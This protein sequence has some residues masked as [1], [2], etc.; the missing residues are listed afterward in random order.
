MLKTEGGL[1]RSFFEKGSVAGNR[2][3][4]PLNLFAPILVQIPACCWPWPGSSLV[5][6]QQRRLRP[7]DCLQVEKLATTAT[8][9]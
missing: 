5:R 2:G 6:R 3:T 7:Q 8:R 9:W 1:E 4:K